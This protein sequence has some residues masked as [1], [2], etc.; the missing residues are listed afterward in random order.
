MFLRSDLILSH[1]MLRNQQ[2]MQ[3]CDLIHNVTTSVHFNPIH[4]PPMM[5]GNLILQCPKDKKK[6]KT[7]LSFKYQRDDRRKNIYFCKVTDQ[8][9]TEENNMYHKDNDRHTC[10]HKLE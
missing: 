1:L 6:G 2:L 10:C 7:G 8:S 9:Y 4:H 5:A 3:D